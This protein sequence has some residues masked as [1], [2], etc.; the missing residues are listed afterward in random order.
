MQQFA[1]SFGRFT[2]KY[3]CLTL[4]FSPK[5]NSESESKDTF[6]DK[7]F[8]KRIAMK[9]HDDTLKPLLSIII[10]FVRDQQV[11]NMFPFRKEI[12]QRRQLP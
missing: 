6:S 11:K 4:V 3:F 8:V 2:K 7:W 5:L 12:V 9:N 10:S 1:G